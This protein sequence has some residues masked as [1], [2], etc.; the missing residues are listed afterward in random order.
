MASTVAGTVAGTI[1]VFPVAGTLVQS[2]LWPI[3]WWSNILSGFFCYRYSGPVSAAA[4]RILVILNWTPCCDQ[5][6]GG[7]VLFSAVAGIPVSSV[8]GSLV[9][10]LLWL[11]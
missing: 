4:G 9:R 6:A 8:A 11:F 1:S 3:C 10:S 7:Q 5:Y 2:L